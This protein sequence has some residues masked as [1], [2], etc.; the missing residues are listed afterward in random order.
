V[1]MQ[2]VFGV[3]PSVFKHPERLSP[4]VSVYLPEQ[5]TVTVENKQTVIDGLKTIKKCGLQVGDGKL[6]I[7]RLRRED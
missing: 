5:Q 6:E 7:K 1:V 4:I 2:G 3:V